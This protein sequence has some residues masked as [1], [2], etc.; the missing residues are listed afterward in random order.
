[1]QSHPRSKTAFTLI[2]LLVVI[3][4]IAL[5]IGILL[6]ALGAARNV[7]RISQAA[8]NQRQINIAMAAYQADNQEFFPLWQ[9]SDV[10]DDPTT[11]GYMVDEPVRW[12]WTTKLAIDNYIPGLEV[13][14]DPTLEG[15][16]SFM[17][18][19][20]SLI[21]G[22]N[23]E[24][25]DKR[26]FNWIHFGYNYVWVGSNLPI[27]SGTR[28]AAARREG[29]PVSSAARVLDMEDATSV[30]VTMGVKDFNP[31]AK[32]MDDSTPTID[33]QGEYGAH[34]F[35]DT[36]FSIGNAGYPHARYN[37][38]FQMCFADGH[39]GTVSAPFTQAEQDADNNGLASSAANGIYGPNGLG[40]P[41]SFGRTGR[42]GVDPGNYFD[43]HASR[44]DN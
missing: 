14:V 2:E 34:V 3:S 31:S 39:V 10:N 7:A 9:R 35:I 21:D 1:M 19:D 24:T 37:D 28:S 6:P 38:S 23:R 13:Y 33:A 42:G 40:D 18:Q 36:T 44:P 29:L 8:S 17:P 20:N 32:R 16:T 41:A 25:L 5:L 11:A 4:I 27:S 26:V 30:V 22:L 12:Y 43:L 15:D